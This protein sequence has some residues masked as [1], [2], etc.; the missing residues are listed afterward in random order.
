LVPV[1]QDC[2][3]CQHRLWAR[4]DNVRTITTL[5]GV[6]RLRLAVRRCNNPDCPRFLRP[7]RPEAE[8]HFALPYHEF[9]L[10][11]ID[12]VGRLRHVEHRSIAEI[13][14]E[15][16][17]RG[18]VVAQRTV[19]NLL[20]RYDELRALAAGAP[21]RLRPRLQAQGRVVLA[22]DGLQPDVG[23]EVLWVV[24]DC[25][26]GEVL[27]AQSL[28]SATQGDLATLLRGVRDAL[29][30]PV[31]AVVSDGQESIRLAVA[32]VFPGVPHQLCQF[33]YLREAARPLYELDRHAK[34]E[35]KKR[36]RGV[37]PL[38]RRAEGRDDPTAEVVRGYC[39]AVRSALT[40]DGRP[41]LDAKG[42]LLNDRLGAIAASLDRVA[43]KR[44][45]PPN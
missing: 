18:I 37:R 36:V 42:L 22:L 20:D 33:H 21:E 45:S 23:H 9:G 11:V 28:L 1:I 35:L 15:L 4:Y 16:T 7:Y 34:K 32:E 3:E 5:D 27:R 12:A 26:S 24:R 14:R 17:R 29:P 13:H 38:E 43:E 41:P 19:T 30:V 6:L 25:L 44:G 8:P 39:A 40:D 2:P 31:K 10:D